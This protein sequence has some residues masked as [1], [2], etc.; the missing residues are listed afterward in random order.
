MCLCIRYIHG[1]C[2]V[3][4]VSMLGTCFACYMAVVWLFVEL[5]YGLVDEGMHVWIARKAIRYHQNVQLVLRLCLGF[6]YV[7]HP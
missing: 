4:F 7:Y 2:G 6:F 1:L 3:P 5:V